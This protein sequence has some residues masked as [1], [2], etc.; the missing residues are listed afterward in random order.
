MLVTFLDVVLLWQ[1]LFVELEQG[2]VDFVS[3]ALLMPPPQT[4]RG[5]NLT[6]FAT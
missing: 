4:R 5:I 6:K 1:S 3:D 2:P